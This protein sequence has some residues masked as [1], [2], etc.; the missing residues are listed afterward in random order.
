[1]KINQILLKFEIFNKNKETVSI[2]KSELIRQNPFVI[3]NLNNVLIFRFLHITFKYL[4]KVLEG[5]TFLRKVNTV[6]N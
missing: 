3:H 1:M 5:F 6:S 2:V 4:L